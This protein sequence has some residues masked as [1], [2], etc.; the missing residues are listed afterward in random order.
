MYINIQSVSVCKKDISMCSK[1][2]LI[3]LWDVY[4]YSECEYM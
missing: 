4:K 3:Y 2:I 1:D